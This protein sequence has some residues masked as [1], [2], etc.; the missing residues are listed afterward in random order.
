MSTT[1]AEKHDEESAVLQG[2]KRLTAL[3]LYAALTPAPVVDIVLNGLSL[4]SVFSKGAS[5]S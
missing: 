4:P 3:N 2:V 1:A 5:N